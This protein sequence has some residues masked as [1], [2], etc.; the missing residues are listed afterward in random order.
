M[1]ILAM[2][3]LLLSPALA[4]DPPASGT[5]PPETPAP[6]APVPEAPAAPPEAPAPLTS[7]AP[8]SLSG[9]VSGI[10]VRGLK[11][12]EEAVIL[13]AITLRAGERLEPWKLHRDINA[14]WRTGFVEDVVVEGISEPPGANGL[15]RVRVI[16]TVKEKPAVREVRLVGNRKIREEDLRE[17]IDIEPFTVPGESR[18]AANVRAIRDKYLEKGYFLV[19]IE[20]VF[21]PVGE[22]LVELSFRITE[23]RKV[24]VQSVDITG[25]EHVPDAK[26]R[27]FMATRP[28]GILPWLTS[29]GTFQADAL[30]NDV[31]VVRSVYLEEGY[32]DV[33]VDAP[34][35]FLSPDKRYIYVEI[36]VT[37]GPQYKLGHLRVAGDFMPEEGLT[38]GSVEA[39]L[40]GKNP[41]DVQAAFERDQKRAEAA[42]ATLPDNWTPQIRRRWLD[43]SMVPMK[44]GDTFKLT[45]MQGALQRVSDLYGDQGYAF[46]NVVPLTQTDPETGVVDITFEI[47]AGAKMRIGRINI[48]GNDPTFDKVVRREIPLNEGDI[49]RGSALRDGRARLERL[50]FFESV[51]ISTPRGAGDDVL[52]VNIDVSE[53]PTGSFSVGAGYGSAESFLFTANI[54]KANFLGLGWLFSLNGN[55]SS[56]TRNGSLSFYEPHLLDSQ[57]T[58]RVDGFYNERSYIENEYQRGGSL[59]IGRYLDQRGDYRIALS[60][61]VEDVGLLSIDEYKERLFGGQMYRNGLTSSVGLSF[62]I[63]RRNN[64]IKATKGFKLLLS[65]ELAGG[66]RLGDSDDVLILFGGDFNYLESKL[67][68]RFYQPLVPKGDW[69]IFKYNLSMGWI[70]STDATIIPY[71]HR[72]RA[73]GITS[74]RGYEPY[75]L[76]P[77]IRAEGYRDYSNPRSTFVGI[78]D[79]AGADDRLV[80][81]G[82]EI[83]VNNFEIESPV[84]RAAQISL[85]GFFDAGNVFGDPWGNGHIDLTDLRTSVGFGVRW[86]SPI[87]PLRFEYGIPLQPYPDER[88]AV[89]DF[90]IGS[91]F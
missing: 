53:R 28:G 15:P 70:T 7:S 45:T 26:I 25:N 30:E 46:A 37:E 6:E 66:F 27:R 55:I 85:V 86:F 16:F 9:V 90:T 35:V 54:Q 8:A 17:V 76:G 23:N 14:I 56:R 89:F 78:D 22:D 64:Q 11:R 5:E 36:H 31:F 43:L 48:T 83:L 20:P 13:D 47:Q 62:D 72:Y 32:V 68:F 91:A 42:G 40:D 82:T 61:T 59:E 73:G 57:W 51:D 77:S 69:L 79:P 74:I 41:E 81:G 33:Q 60:Y 88:K 87:G 80:I 12:V 34:K 10:E 3:L 65:T 39:I 49:Y 19:E 44:T 50:G 84:I 71:I 29:S 58:L 2:L 1:S 24:I 4:G 18:I 75:A 63:D 38:S 21:K 52:D 67:N